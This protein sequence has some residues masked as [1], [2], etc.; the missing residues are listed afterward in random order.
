MQN[1]SISRALRILALISHLVVAV[2]PAF[3]GEPPEG[4]RKLFNG[5][6][7]TGWHGMPHF[8]PYVLAAMPEAKRKQT[9]A[10]LD[11][12][13]QRTLEVE[14]D[15]LV[16]DGKG[17]YLTTDKDF[18]DIELLDRIQDGAVGRQRHL[19]PRHAAGADLG[20]YQGGRQVEPRRRQR[21]R[22]PV[23]QQPR[24]AGQGP[25]GPGRQAVRPVEQVP[26]P[27]GGRAG[28]RV[29]ERQAGRRS[30]S[31]GELLAEQR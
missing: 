27:P 29:S 18:G 17:R 11:R 4:F 30:R 15:E 13:R 21:Q 25:A 23:E 9:I 22:R 31:A 1:R 8:D 10:D 19:P 7:L 3:A 6:D 26:H 28:D 5:K 16:N 2:V 24:L 20:L 12:G 14:N